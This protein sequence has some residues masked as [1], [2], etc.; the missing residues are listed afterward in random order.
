MNCELRIK[1]ELSSRR[2]NPVDSIYKPNP[3]PLS[4]DKGFL[5]EILQTENKISERLDLGCS[6][7]L[8][9]ANLL[10]AKQYNHFPESP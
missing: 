2:R 5:V 1:E 9:F 3:L 8:F 6:E 7:I 4:S 10:L